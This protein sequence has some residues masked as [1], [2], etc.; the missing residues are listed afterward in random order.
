LRYKKQKKYLTGNAHHPEP[1]NCVPVCKGFFYGAVQ[2]FF[3]I[4]FPVF[5]G[6]LQWLFLSPVTGITNHINWF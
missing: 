2:D 5:I 3:Y 4:E 6:E 1:V